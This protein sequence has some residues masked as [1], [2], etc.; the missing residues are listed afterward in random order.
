MLR[1]HPLPIRK[2]TIANAPY[3][4]AREALAVITEAIPDEVGRAWA[5]RVGGTIVA[6][7]P[8]SLPSVVIK[9]RLADAGIDAQL[10]T[11]VRPGK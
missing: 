6:E 3:G 1:Y 9:R 5:E 2:I 8:T 11:T 4:S 7:V 10:E